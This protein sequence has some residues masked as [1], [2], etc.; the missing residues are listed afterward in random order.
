MRPHVVA[1]PVLDGMPVFDIGVAGEVFGMPRPDLLPRPYEVQVCGIGD[2]PVRL[3]GAPLVLRVDACLD[4]LRSADTVVVPALASFDATVPGELVD[5]LQEA[6]QRGTRIASVC[7]G[8]FALAAAGLLDG[9]RATTHWMHAAAL[10]ER[11]PA[12]HVDPDVLY[13]VD[14]QVAT[15]AG[16]AAGIDLCLELVRR[17]HGTAIA[18]EVARRL[19][20][21]PHRQGGQ[22]QYVSTPLPTIP[23]SALAPVLDWARSRLDQQLTL[24]LLARRADTTT[25]TLTA[26]SPPSWGSRRCSG[27]PPSGSA[28]PANSWRTPV[29]RSSRSPS[30]AAWGR[31]PTCDCTSSARPGR[32]PPLTGL[33]LPGGRRRAE[34][35]Y[36]R[37]VATLIDDAGQLLRPQGRPAGGVFGEGPSQAN[38]GVF[39]GRQGTRSRRQ[40]SELGE[41]PPTG[42]EPVTLRFLSCACHHMA[43]LRSRR[44]YL[45]KPPNRLVDTRP[46]IASLVI[47]SCG[48]VVGWDGLGFISEPRGPCASTRRRPATEP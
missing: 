9:R 28:G 25:R 40:D 6:F 37:T 19:V 13:E 20:V 26:G 21:P 43:S 14:G 35:I 16:T 17:D 34:L 18:A 31:R 7:T 38:L 41:A 8:A 42:L 47:V 45:Q 36:R 3:Q 24:R 39:R 23:D 44:R 27:S 15:S 22:A 46:W 33:P 48:I 30:R 1:V 5:A 12:V 4:V 32:R 10:A 29:C 11:F 2:E